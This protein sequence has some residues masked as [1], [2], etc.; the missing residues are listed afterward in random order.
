MGIVRSSPDGSHVYFVANGVLTGEENNGKKAVAGQSNLYGYDTVTDKIKFVATAPGTIVPHLAES[1]EDF[2]GRVRWLSSD[3]QRPA[4]TTPDGRYLVFSGHLSTA[5]DTN[6]CTV[7]CPLAVYRYDFQTGALEWVSRQAPGKD[8]LVAPL[9]GGRDGAEAHIDDWNRAISGCPPK[10]L[11]SEAEEAEFSCPEGQYDGKYIIFVTAEQAQGSSV[12]DAP[13]L[14]EWHEREG[15][16][17][18]VHMISDGR[19]PDGIEPAEGTAQQ[20]VAMS[21]SG[22]DIFFVTSTA[23]VGQDTDTLHD[24][25]DARIGGGF[26]APP[27]L[28]CSGEGCQ[29]L[30]PGHEPFPL[31]ASSLFTG[32]QNAAPGTIPVVPPTQSKPKPPTRA[33][34]LAKALKA[35]KKEPRKKRKACE[36]QARKKYGA[37]AKPQPAKPKKGR[38]K[39]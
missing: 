19:A 36:A 22:S 14:Y 32:G 11:R 31:A 3:E 35:C 38:A 28:P 25:Y 20:P 30:P 15:R 2:E 13:T 21:A 16:E 9:P 26:P 23:L 10:G 1:V 8:A 39:K 29:P 18:E 4:Q 34:L 27:P 12:S 37:K 7:S 33:Q 24:L 6:S 17:G 5:G